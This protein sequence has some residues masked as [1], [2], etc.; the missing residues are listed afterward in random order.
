M[1]YTVC[2]LC[3]IHHYEDCPDCFGFGFHDDGTIMSAFDAEYRNYTGWTRC[4][5]CG[6]SPSGVPEKAVTIESWIEYDD[7]IDVNYRI[8]DEQ[9]TQRVGRFSVFAN[10]LRTLDYAECEGMLEEYFA[11]K[12]N[13]E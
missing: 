6:S 7:Y 9:H 4:N 11:L 8:G 1:G 3:D 13:P 2:T 5:K 10:S 12:G